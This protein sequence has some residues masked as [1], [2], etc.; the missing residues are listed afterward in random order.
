T[1]FQDK[2]CATV[3]H[4]LLCIGGTDASKSWFITAAGSYLD[5]WDHLRAKDGS[6]TVR[7]RNLS[8][9]ELQSAPFTV[10][11]H[12]Q[13]LGDLVVIPSRCFSQKVH[14]GTSASLSWQRVTMK[15]LESFVYHDQIIRQRYGL[16]SVPA[17]FTFLHLTCSGYVSV[18]RTTSKRPSAIPFPDASPLLQQWLRLFDEV[19]RPTYCEDDDNL[20]LVDLGPSSFCA[21]CGGE[22]FRSVFCCTGS[23]IRD[24][25]P[26][27]ESAIIVCTSCYI[28]GRVCRCGNMAPSRTGALSDLLDFRNNVIEV[29][30]DLPE[31]VEED[32]LSDGEFSI[33]RAGIALYSRTCTPRIQSSHRVPELSLIN[34]KSCHANRCYKHILSTYNTHSSGALLTRLSDDSSKMWHSLHQLRRDSYTEG[35]AWTKEMIRTGSPA[36]LAD[37]LVYFASNFS[38][39]PI[40]RA[41]F[42]G[43]YDAIAVS[44]FVAFRISLKH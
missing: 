43:F 38:A 27:H 7:L 11:V 19:V 25:Q 32:L 18:H 16:P 28:D 13:K 12:E 21:F 2:S 10:Y 30:R 33:F 42:A 44:F 36:P 23:C 26:N 40:N 4:D 14:C 15:G 1:P 8:S 39:T 24:D 41:L 20:P 35:Y 22:L 17:A 31:N 37:R 34:C 3:V 5:V 9:A 29:L 6:N